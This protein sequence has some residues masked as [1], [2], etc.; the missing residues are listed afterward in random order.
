MILRLAAAVAALAG[1]LSLPVAALA[2]EISAFDPPASAS[3]PVRF[4]FAR[5]KASIAIGEKV[6]YTA[7]GMFC[8]G[9]HEVRATNR[10]DE[11]NTAQ[12]AFAF[13]SELAAQGLAQAAPEVSAFDA[14]AA[15][16][17]A[18]YRVGGVLQALSFD[19]CTSGTDRKGSVNVTVKWE[20]FA[21]KLQKVVFTKVTSGSVT[22]DSW[23]SVTGRDFESRAYT[24]ALRQLMS[25]PDF[26]ALRPID[27]P[28]ATP[29]AAAT[30]A[31]APLHVKSAPALA[32]GS[33]VNAAALRQAVVTVM[34]DN[35][36]GSGFYIADGYLLTDRHVV[37]TT[38]YVKVKLASGRVVVGEVVRDDVRRDV[39]LI[40][41]E[42]INDIKPLH[43]SM[44]EPSV[45]E[46]VFAIG[47]PLGQ[48]L[49]GTFT[50]GVLS[51]QRQN[52][53]LDYLQSDVAIN[54]G[55]SGGP[56]LNGSSTVIGLAV[57][58]ADKAHGLA[59]FIPIRDAANSLQLV[60]D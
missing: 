13:K 5:I 27:G 48:E 7:A 47:S 54:P 16:V 2:A 36:S 4:E 18:D 17:E 8:M 60:F 32:G 46:D 38:H 6:G 10:L 34:H 29:V 21:P 42:T 49:A 56:L 20:V 59:F 30:A 40:K 41:T 14:P 37:G 26:R 25:D 24:A 58:L 12:A 52:N 22:A 43:V 45:G 35:S 3:A 23:E 51:G 57:L 55:N 44:A 9:R 39:A 33:Q 31:L 15:K 11:I 53:G 28:S 50:R 1:S 19:E